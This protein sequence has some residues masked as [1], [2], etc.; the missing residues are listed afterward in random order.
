MHL[1]RV[2]GAIDAVAVG[3]L[4]VNASKDKTY[5]GQRLV[6]SLLASKDFTRNL[7]NLAKSPRQLRDLDWDPGNLHLGPLSLLG[8]SRTVVASYES[9]GES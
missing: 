8:L 4:G 5:G 6:L 3:R 9:S 2:I 1:C 7:I